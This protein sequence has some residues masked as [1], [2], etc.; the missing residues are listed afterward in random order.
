MTK[1]MI[2]RIKKIDD[3]RIFQRWKQSSNVQFA[4][5]NL[6]YGQNG[7]GKSTLADL[8]LGCAVYAADQSGQR[9]TRH[10]E[11]VRSGVLLTVET[12]GTKRDVDRDDGEFWG[13]VRVF[14]KGF[15]EQNLAFGDK[16]GPHPQALLTIGKTSVD[17]EVEL[18][19]LH[20]KRDEVRS[21]SSLAE[22]AKKAAE[23]AMKN[24]L[25][26]VAKVVVDALLGT[27]VS[28]YNPRSYNKTNVEKL[29][30]A[31]D[32]DQTLFD[33]ASTDLAADQKTAT[34][35]AMDRVYLP[36]R[37][38]V[39]GRDAV[40]D[41]RAL[42]N[43][44]VVNEAI[45]ALQGHPDRSEWVQ[46]GINLHKGLDECLF[47]GQPLTAD[48]YAELNAHFDGSFTRLQGD[49]DALVGR[50]EASVTASKSYLDSLPADTS[51]YED[52]RV[53]LQRARTTY[54][55]EHEAYFQAVEHIVAAL[56]Q[57]RNNPFD[58]AS[59]GLD[60]TLKVPD[61]AGLEKVVAE[62][63]EK[64]SKHDEEACSA[65][66]RVELYYVKQFADEYKRLKKEAEDEKL[67]AEALETKASELRDQIASLE[68]VGG[69]PVPGAEELTDNVARLLGRVELR[70]STAL[71]GKH[72][73]I[74][75]N[76]APA[77]NL[78]EG[79]QTA[80]ALLYFLVS[81][82]EDKIE[83]GPPIV[84]IDDPV[85]SLDNSILFGASAHI[86]SELVAKT[87]VSQ[88]FLMT[89][90]FELFRQW[91]VQMESVPKNVRNEEG[92]YTAYEMRATCVADNR[93]VTGRIP[94]LVPWPLNDKKMQKLRSQYHFLFSRVADGL[95]TA[96]S[97]LG[98]A[99]QMEIM[100]LLPNA[101]RRM[102][103]S[104]LSFHRP[105]KMGSFHGSMRAVLED[106]P[107]LDDSVR[108]HVE[109][110]LHAYS[111][112]EEADISRSL[113]LG[114][115]MAVLRSLFRFM[116]HVDRNHVSSM[117]TALGIKEQALL[118]APVSALQ[119]GSFA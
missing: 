102:M 45:D 87:K 86:W 30:S 68:N 89:H 4:R 73:V 10:T 19:E 54:Q 36:D 51:V 37:Q 81:V 1:A 55:E 9:D 35:G 13:R 88:V 43:V 42:L 70:F 116:Y 27:Q 3:Y 20:L 69:N 22:K 33:D 32:S 14:N 23:T 48:R 12:D 93:R 50:L 66:R 95:L 21:K 49:I 39:S 44:D 62:H 80:I 97:G 71:D 115:S 58:V 15:V 67:E 91:L 79:E 17:A 84:V 106:R 65:A 31:F 29:L 108:T 38:E 61:T 103:E 25:T 26:Q 18:A 100:A 40:A 6:I 118:G 111:H 77:T 2:R 74:E 98:L 82:R 56:K 41:V 104:F 109:R 11:V 24:R 47:C 105:D 59:L 92:G 90:N 63:A 60:V 107:G 7:S 85:S 119:E 76:G 78:S 117:C 64:N 94:R 83:G 46:D 34:S 5:I 16:E 99:E 8:M 52:L 53:N 96:D 101:A 112:L 57:K 113:D 72:Y 28:K 110:Y 75:R 114:E